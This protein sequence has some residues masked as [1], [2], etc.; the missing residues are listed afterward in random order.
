MVNNLKIEQCDPLHP[1]PPTG[2]QTTISIYRQCEKKLFTF[3]L[4]FLGFL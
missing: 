2:T 4:L 3:S 1:H